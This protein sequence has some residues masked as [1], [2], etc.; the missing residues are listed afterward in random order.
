MCFDGREHIEYVPTLTEYLRHEYH[1]HSG[2]R[3]DGITYPSTQ[4]RNGENIVLFANHND[5]RP[6][7]EQDYVTT[8]RSCVSTRTASND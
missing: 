2:H 4:A 3:L 8:H 1:T 5:L 7:D 6:E